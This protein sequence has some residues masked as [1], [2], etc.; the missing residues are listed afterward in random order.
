MC[1]RDRFN[2]TENS[3][4]FLARNMNTFVVGIYMLIE[5]GGIHFRKEFTLRFKL[6]TSP[7]RSLADYV[8]TIPAAHIG[9]TVD[10][11]TDYEEGLQT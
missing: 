8:L 2:S 7:I 11:C 10:W 4:T 3:S 5:V 6:N 9:H 1:I